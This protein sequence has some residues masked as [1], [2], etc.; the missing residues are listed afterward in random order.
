MSIRK[1]K[2]RGNALTLQKKGGK[3]CMNRVV[4]EEIYPARSSSPGKVCMNRVVMEDTH[5]TRY[6]REKPT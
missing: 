2:R 6:S 3:L 5:P 1:V 4:M